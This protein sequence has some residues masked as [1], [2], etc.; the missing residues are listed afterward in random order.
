MFKLIAFLILV[1]DFIILNVIASC[2]SGEYV[3]CFSSPKKYEYFTLFSNNSLR[4]SAVITTQIILS[5][6]NLAQ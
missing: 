6:K 4:V 5:I 3:F 1:L 2:M